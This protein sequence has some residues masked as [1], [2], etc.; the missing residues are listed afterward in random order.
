M[1]LALCDNSYTVCQISHTFSS[2]FNTDL[3]RDAIFF[4]FIFLFYQTTFHHP[5]DSQFFLTS[6]CFMAKAT[7]GVRGHTCW[8]TCWYVRLVVLQ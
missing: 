7:E 4:I 6:F 5:M 8:Y 2:S 3:V 1:S